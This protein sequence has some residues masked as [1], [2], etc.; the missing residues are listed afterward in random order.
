MMQFPRRIDF[1]AR[2]RYL[3]GVGFGLCAMIPV[4]FLRDRPESYCEQSELRSI[5]KCKNA[6]CISLQ[7]GNDLG[8]FRLSHPKY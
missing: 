3:R 8:T 1:A 2:L 6:G 4:H 7:H 5:T